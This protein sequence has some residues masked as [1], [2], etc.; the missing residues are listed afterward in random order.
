MDAPKPKRDKDK[1]KRGLSGRLPV[2]FLAEYPMEECINRL[3]RGGGYKQETLKDG[4]YRFW[5]DGD[6][7]ELQIKVIPWDECASRIVLERAWNQSPVRDDQKAATRMLAF[8][9]FLGGLGILLNDASRLLLIIGLLGASIGLLVL[10]FYG[11]LSLLRKE[12]P[13]LSL[14]KILGTTQASA[15]ARQKSKT[16]ENDYHAHA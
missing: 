10:L 2:E 9:L 8:F 11:A 4:G 13:I 16:K 7:H 1:R 14:Q 15:F 3:L 6:L 5:V 12:E